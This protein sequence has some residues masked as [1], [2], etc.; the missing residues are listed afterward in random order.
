AHARNW[1][2]SNRRGFLRGIGAG[3]AAA[4]MLPGA[5]GAGAAFAQ[6]AGGTLR[7]ARGQES[8][9]LDPHKTSLLV[10]HEIAWQIYDS[11]IYLD[12]A[13]TVYPGLALSWEFSNEN[14]TVT[15]KLRPGVTFHDGTPFNAEAVAK[16]VAR[17]QAPETASPNAFLLGPL[18]KVEA[19]DD[20]TV[21]YHYTSPF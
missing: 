19:I 9:T 12:E 4:A 21:A 6:Q 7:I 11:L 17:H 5:F 18:E 14:K 3:A 1:A 15:F 13:G 20:L 8:D 10:A 2:R 16:T